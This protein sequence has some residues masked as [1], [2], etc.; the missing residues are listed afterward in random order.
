MRQQSDKSPTKTRVL[1]LSRRFAPH[2]GGVEKHVE[3]LSEQLTQRN[4]Q[5]T[6]VTEQHDSAVPLTET[7]TYYQVV[8]IPQAYL[9][10]KTAMWFWMLLHFNLF[11]SADIIH[12]HDVFWWVIPNRFL[13][14]WK[15][16]FTTFHGYEGSEPPTEKAVRSRKLSENLSRGC[17]CVGAWMRKWYR[18]T[19]D[20]VI[21]GA[22]DFRAAKKTT[23]RNAVF[24][25]RLSVDTGI[26]DYIHGVKLLHGKVA[27][28]IYGEGEL[29]PQVLEEIYDS[30]YIQ[31]NGVA[32][33]VEKLLRSHR[34]AFISRYL[35]MIEAMQ[36]GR[37]VFA[38][39]NNSIKRDYLEDFPASSSVFLFTF[40]EELAQELGYVL[41]HA[42]KENEH[43][44]IAQI[45]AKEQ[46]WKK[47]AEI[48]EQLWKK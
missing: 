47:I 43:V 29:L 9:S 8:R 11:V 2:V 34:F 21:Y 37:Y 4:Y 48:Y 41:D 14:F 33:E 23:K 20:F 42:E 17:I 16:Y 31:Y 30:P 22:A 18:A 32:H 39:W 19:P 6:I 24:I 15:K 38:H 44:K 40:P 46:T 35:G 13:L 3:K 12:A 7:H 28:D 10:S 1:F 36:S 5:I 45:W 26:L 27:L 25:G